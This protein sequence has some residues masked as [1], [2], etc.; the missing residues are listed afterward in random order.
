MDRSVFTAI[1]RVGSIFILRF[2][3]V[4]LSLI[5]SLLKMV[6][7]GYGCLD[8]LLNCCILSKTG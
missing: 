3:I 5:P 1:Q 6:I 7:E 4:H 2:Y 8:E